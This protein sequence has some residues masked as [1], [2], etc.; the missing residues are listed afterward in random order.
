LLIESRVFRFK[1]HA[2][3]LDVLVFLVPDIKTLPPFLK[4]KHTAQLSIKAAI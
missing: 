3:F 1:L 2:L 4:K